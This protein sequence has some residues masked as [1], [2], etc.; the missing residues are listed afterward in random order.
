MPGLQIGR[1]A[2]VPIIISPSWLLPAAFLTVFY[3]S[4]FAPHGASP[5]VR[6][7]LL[8]FGV[9]VLVAAS[10]LVHEVAHVVAARLQ[11]LPVRRV[12]IHLL[13]G[14][15]EVL[16]KP[17]TAAGDYLVTI[18]G[19]VASL[20]LAAIGRAFFP[21]AQSHEARTYLA[22]FAGV[23]L[24]LAVLNLLPGL[25]L[26]G[27]RVVRAAVWRLTR[28]ELRATVAAANSGRVIAALIAL[29]PIVAAV[30]LSDGSGDNSA[31]L[32]AV[33]G[34]LVGGYI[35]VGASAELRIARVQQA[36]ARVRLRSMVRSALPVPADLPLS[37]ALRRVRETGARAMVT[38]DHAG[39]PDGLVSEA[40]VAATPLQRQAWVEVS[41]LSRRIDPSLTVLA[42]A[43]G[44]TLLET[45]R[46]T[47]ASEYLVV[48]DSGEVLGVLATSDVQAVLRNSPEP[49]APA[50]APRQPRQ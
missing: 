32:D 29:G 1:V 25:P 6:A 34:V 4:D 5:G 20:L 18:A 17:A 33:W 13:G 23:N 37:E 42:D 3:A 16:R 26:D 41:S 48:E 14:V 31:G 44:D 28:D 7:H 24:F 36:L 10:V 43:S 50:P 40:A 30:A 8:A 46:A 9:A 45:L 39:R 47:P 15:S 27:G 2:G 11:D 38:V 22:Y 35:W 19:P 12:V 49:A 21:L